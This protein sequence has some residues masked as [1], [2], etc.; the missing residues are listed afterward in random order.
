[1]RSEQYAN[2]YT[3]VQI[4]LLKMKN[5]ICNTL[6]PARIVTVKISFEVKWRFLKLFKLDNAL[7]DFGRPSITLSVPSPIKIH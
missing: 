7:T 5:F 4:S 2:L 1:M 6:I 3:V